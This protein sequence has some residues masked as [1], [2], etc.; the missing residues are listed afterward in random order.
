[1]APLRFDSPTGLLD[2][3]DRTFPD[4]AHLSRPGDDEWEYFVYQPMVTFWDDG[5]MGLQTQEIDGFDKGFFIDASTIEE[6]DRAYGRWEGPHGKSYL[7][8]SY[9]PDPL[10]LSTGVHPAVVES[11][12]R[13]R[14]EWTDFYTLDPSLVGL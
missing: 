12:R 11:A 2:W 14:R 6:T 5:R 4:G 7:F 10:I 3:L 13:E 8:G 9:G 1:M